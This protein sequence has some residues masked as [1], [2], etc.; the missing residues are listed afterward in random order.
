[1]MCGLLFKE[2]YRDGEAILCVTTHKMLNTIS[3]GF[4]NGLAERLGHLL[5]LVCYR[6]AGNAS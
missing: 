5:L 2:N 4:T 3:Y 6:E 1:M